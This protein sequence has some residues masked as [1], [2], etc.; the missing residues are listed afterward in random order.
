MILDEKLNFR[1]HI[2]EALEKAKKGLALMKFLSKL[3]DRKTLVLTYTMHVRPHLEYG[4]IIFH[5]CGK[6]LMDCLERIQYQ[7]GLIATG[8]WKNTNKEKLYAEL[9]WESL[10]E[11]RNLRRLLTYHKIISGKT[12]PYLNEFVQSEPLNANSTLRYQNTFSL[13]ATLSG[14]SLTPASKLLTLIP[15]SQSFF[16][17]AGHVNLE[18][19][20]LMIGTD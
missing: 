5:G 17:Q 2:K 10:S 7:A 1:E 13:T 8:C 16:P 12:P 4:D 3:V 9:G 15:L 20:M 18:P 6:S 19:L 14:M 11:R